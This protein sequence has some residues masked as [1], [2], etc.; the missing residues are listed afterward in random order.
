M[1][2][3]KSK[4]KM[5]K[6][7][8]K[9]LSFQNPP[10]SPAGRRDNVVNANNLKSNFNRG[11]SGPIISII[12]AEA[13]GRKSS[14][15]SNFDEPTSPKVSCMGQIQL[16]KNKISK[17]KNVSPPATKA[18]LPP[19]SQSKKKQSAAIRNIFS[20]RKPVAGRKSDGS[21]DDYMHPVPDHGAAPSLNHMKR[22]ASSRDTFASFDWTTAQIAP[23]DR[24]FFSD[25]EGEDEA[26]K[27]QN[28]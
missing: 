26:S 15:N 17:K 8:P 13:R 4:N 5:L 23:E 22:F 28:D 18:P 20:N 25:E 3:P 7:L 6:F 14:K 11:F 27:F 1:E 19:P 9:A 16:R 10:F 21:S 2:K 24:E 12:P